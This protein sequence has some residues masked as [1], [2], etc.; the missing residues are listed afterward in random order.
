MAVRD[1]EGAKTIPTSLYV[2]L[3]AFQ[4]KACTEGMHK[5]K[6]S[7]NIQHGYL[8][9]N[10]RPMGAAALPLPKAFSGG[11]ERV[12]VRVAHARS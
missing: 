10:R 2:L 1:K 7:P 9:R 3:T 11:F 6:K 12:A 8:G 4:M 5:K